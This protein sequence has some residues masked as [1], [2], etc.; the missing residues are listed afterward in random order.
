MSFLETILST[1]RQNDSFLQIPLKFP[2]SLKGKKM[3][4][5]YSGENKNWKKEEE[6][7]NAENNSTLQ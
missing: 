4:C 6:C 5:F 3:L 7:N 2:T 1:S